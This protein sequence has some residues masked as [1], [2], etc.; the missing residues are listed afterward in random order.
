MIWYYCYLVTHFVCALGTAG[1]IRGVRKYLKEK[2][3]NI[4]II[5]VLAEE[6]NDIPGVLSLSEI[7]N[8]S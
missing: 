4:K 6:N 7:K 2:N 8:L 5:G 3:N 1:T